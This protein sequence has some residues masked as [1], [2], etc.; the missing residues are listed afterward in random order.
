MYKD[1]E[2]F[3][4]FF[5]RHRMLLIFYL[6]DIFHNLFVQLYDFEAF[7]ACLSHC[8]KEITIGYNEGTSAKVPRMF[9][10]GKE[11]QVDK[12]LRFLED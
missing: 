10:G 7:Y 1:L 12:L 6:K 2:I 3:Y 11:I 5:K 9:A 8:S 4:Y